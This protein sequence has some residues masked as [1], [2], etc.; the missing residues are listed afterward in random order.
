MVTV[1]DAA[2]FVPESVLFANARTCVLLASGP[3]SVSKSQKVVLKSGLRDSILHEA[4]ALSQLRACPHVVQ[5]LGLVHAGFEGQA[6]FRQRDGDC[7]TLVLE[8][9]S[10]GDLFDYAATR[11][12]GRFGDGVVSR[13]MRQLLVAVRAC[14]DAGVIHMDLKSE[15]IFVRRDGSIAL[16][17]FE[18]WAQAGSQVSDLRGTV[19]CIPPEVY[20]VH[21]SAYAAEP[22]VDVW[23]LGVIA[24]ELLTGQTLHSHIA[25]ADAACSAHSLPTVAEMQTLFNRSLRRD[26]FTFHHRAFANVSAPARAFVLACCAA[27]PGNRPTCAALTDGCEWVRDAP[28]SMKQHLLPQ[29]SHVRPGSRGVFAATTAAAQPPGCGAGFG[30]DAAVCKVE[31]SRRRSR[32]HE[33]RACDDRRAPSAHARDLVD[34]DD[35][36]PMGMERFE[37]ADPVLVMGGE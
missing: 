31:P 25:G 28:E 16:G 36:S 21:P 23:A 14:H 10:R 37:A 32:K 30:S 18:T 1:Y 34:H 3:H 35:V 17:D 24:F 19:H 11:K 15:N 6:P 2:T 26:G 27:R 13:M 8:Y 33:K 9:A 22:A 29:K 5:L 7:A 4:E 20:A 12:A